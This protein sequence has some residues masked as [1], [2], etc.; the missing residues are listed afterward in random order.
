MNPLYRNDRAGQFPKSWYA[1][2][3]DIPAERLPLYGHTT[4]DVCV[5]GA[6]FTGLSAALHL[7]QK[8][9][10]VVVLEAHR[11][12]FGASGRNGGQVGSGYNKSQEWLAKRLGD[13]AAHA[14]WDM[15]EEAKADLRAYAA[16]HAP[17]AAYK[18]GVVH[19]AYTAR[20]VAAEHREADYLARTYGYNKIENLDRNQ[21]TDIVKTP[22]YQG[23]TLDHGAGHLHPLRYV[24]GLARAA[25]AAGVQ[26]FERS[27][28]HQITK[29][30]RTEV[31]TNK[32]RVDAQ[33]VIVAGNGYLPGIERKIAAKVM[34]INSFIGATAPLGE[35]AAEVLTRDIAVADNKFVVNYYRM[36]ED[37]RLLFGGR[38]SYSLGFPKDIKTAL[39]QRMVNLFPQLEGVGFDYVWGGTLGITTTR[40]PAVQR[41]APNI[42]SA[43]GFSGHGVALSGFA[44]KVMAEAIAGQAGRF[45]VLASLPTP[46]FPGAGVLRAPLLTL[47]MTWFAMRDRLGL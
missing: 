41:V 19:G 35:K 43:A 38:E 2:S 29:G 8:G 28:V 45:D 1:A 10:S 26:I 14:L 23:G 39:N 44:G 5:I 6:G 20:D 32:G 16:A 34:P 25:E 46:S 42:L 3:T 11:A 21:L 31:R 9:L 13:G 47:A 17:D 27:E 40:L 36:S 4:A 33:F 18:S 30:V 37:N 22:L 15:A 7:A 12:G 24:L